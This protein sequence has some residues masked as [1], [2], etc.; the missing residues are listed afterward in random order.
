M[1]V[2]ELDDAVDK[3]STDKPVVIITPSYE[4]RPPDNAKKFV[5]WL[6]KLAAKKAQLPPGTKYAVFG[7]GNSDWVHTFHRVPRL[8]DDTLASLGCER[9]LDVDFANV[10]RDLTGP[11]E[12]WSEKLCLTL[13]GTTKQ[14]LPENVGVDIE[15]GS[16]TSIAPQLPDGEQMTVGV[17]TASRELADA[18]IGA[19]K[20]HVE[21]QLPEGGSYKSGDYLLIQGR[22]P[23]ET[24]SRVMKQFKLTAGD[25]MTVRSSKKNFLPARP[26]SIEHFLRSTVELA[27][28]ITQR[29]L[30]ILATY[31][32]EGSEATSKLAA[33]SE[34]AAYSQILDK[35]YSIIDVLE[36]LPGLNLP[37]GVY[38]DL[39]LPLVPRPYSISSSPIHTADGSIASLTFDVFEAPATSGHG[40]F[41]GVASSYLANRSLGESVQCLV[42]PTKLAF[43]LPK[44]PST[45]IIMQAAGTGIAPMRAFLQE[46]AALKRK[47][48]VKFGPALLFFGC[49]HPMKDYLYSSELAA[50]QKEGIVEVSSTSLIHSRKIR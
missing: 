18:S 16:S 20:H 27:A 50:W 17:I 15:I 34:E 9:I 43:R 8:I 39:L 37:F 21:I 1:E 23:D 11:W 28:P 40:T 31:A 13:S 35:R 32:G 41:R 3:L 6:E 12:A 48:S 33:L 4:G 42:R 46:R 49:R 44:D 29:Q 30:G 5:A 14:E 47:S 38:I 26:V 22:N 45:P 7:V 10:K 24:V 25:L 19:P 2:Q 36:D